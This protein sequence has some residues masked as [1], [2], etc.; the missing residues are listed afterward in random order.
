MASI[1]HISGKYEKA[2]SMPGQKWV[3]T[4][5][6]DNLFEVPE[7]IPSTVDNPKKITWALKDNARTTTFETKNGTVLEKFSFA[8]SKKYSGS[9]G[10]YL[11]AKLDGTTETAGTFILGHCEPKIT[12]ARS[13]GTDLHYGDPVNVHLETEGLNGNALTIEVYAKKNNQL[14]SSYNQ[15]CIN[16]EVDFTMTDT[17]VWKAFV[18]MS[19][20]EEEQQSKDCT[21]LEEFYIKVKNKAD[22]AYVKDG[23]GKEEVISLTLQ[24]ETLPKPEKPAN[25][26]PAKV[27]K[28]DKSPMVTGIIDLQKIAVKTAYDVCDDEL[29]SFNDYPKFWILKGKNYAGAEAYFH[30]MKT[31]NTAVSFSGSSTLYDDN[32]KPSTIPVT[33][34]SDKEFKFAATFKTILSID[35]VKI[36]VRDKDNKYLFNI[37]DHKKEPTGREFEVEFESNNT[38]YKDTVEYLPNFELIFEYSF[39]EKSWTPLGNAQLCLYITHGDPGQDLISVS[40]NGGALYTSEDGNSNIK[41]NFTGKKAILETFLYIGCKFAKGAKTDD[42]IVDKIF[43]HLKSLSV[44]RA[45]KPGIMG[46]W[47]N[48]SSLHASNMPFRGV[49]CMLKTGDGRCGEWSSFFQDLCKIQSKSLF[50]NKFFDFIIVPTGSMD[51]NSFQNSLFLVKSWTINDPNAP[52]DNGGKAQ[53]TSNIPLNLFWDHVFTK[54][55]NKYYDPS[56]G[57]QSSTVFTDDDLLL[58][59]YSSKALSGILYAK[60]DPVHSDIDAIKYKPL[61]GYYMEPFNAY[62]LSTISMNKYRYKTILTS[63]EKELTKRVRLK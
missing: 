9:Y 6:E 35:G 56:Y 13:A 34:R 11:E 47:R 24:G 48:T 4:A 52:V 12:N 22:S 3:L 36:R 19:R 44:G 20:E 61:A 15:E 37:K 46:Y 41:D 10:Y 33:F 55:K 1:Q 8:V 60:I 62:R 63:M 57:L 54:Y 26:T 32:N 16:G 58:A 7:W 43:N 51:S 30:W 42:E 14:V 31:R 17:Y 59:D 23:A 49:R 50:T 38:P 25:Q 27:G 21:E 40:V 18:C 29:N 53:D 5:E 39:D 45:R 28:P 2:L